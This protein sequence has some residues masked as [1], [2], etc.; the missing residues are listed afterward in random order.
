MDA[1]LEALKAAN[2][3]RIDTAA[4][5]PIINP[6]ASE[7][8]LGAAAARGDFQIDTKVMYN[9]TGG[10]GT[11]APAAVE[12]S[13]TQSLSKL[14]IPK[15]HNDTTDREK[16]DLTILSRS[17]SSPPKVPTAARPSPTK[18]PHYKPPSP[19]ATPPAPES[20]ISPRTP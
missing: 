15:V 4:L 19:P 8:L 9:T 20:A 18:P 7:K 14:Q 2:I 16:P 10:D 1:L 11:M 5:Y 17:T 3:T 6:G 12:A 13:V